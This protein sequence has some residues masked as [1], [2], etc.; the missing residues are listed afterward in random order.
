VEEEMPA[1]KHNINFEAKTLASGVYYYRIIAGSFVE[2]KK[3][4]LIR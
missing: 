3:M 2:T 1:G 4:M